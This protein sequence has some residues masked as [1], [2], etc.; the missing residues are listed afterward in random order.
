MVVPDVKLKLTKVPGVAQEMGGANV[1]ESRDGEHSG[2]EL[3]A[4]LESDTIAC[5]EA[6]PLAGPPG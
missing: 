6:V 5:A 3:E 4:V 1:K 2:S